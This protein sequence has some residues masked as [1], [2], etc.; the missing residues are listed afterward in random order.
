MK[1]V[2]DDI[3]AERDALLRRALA[4][5]FTAR[6][7]DQMK[8]DRDDLLRQSR[9]DVARIATLEEDLL[10]FRRA[11]LDFLKGQKECDTV[12]ECTDRSGSK[13]WEGAVLRTTEL[14]SGSVG[15]IRSILVNRFIRKLKKVILLDIMPSNPGVADFARKVHFLSSAQGACRQLSDDICERTREEADNDEGWNYAARNSLPT[16]SKFRPLN[17]SFVSE[18]RRKR[19]MPGG[20]L[21]LLRGKFFDVSTKE[22]RGA[23]ALGICWKND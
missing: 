12:H 3:K 21:L 9:D 20:E 13:E 19:R 16:L 10:I 5:A 6:A 15:R 11:A 22:A 23:A 8:T 4:D 7:F 18:I 2:Y 17:N 14:V 1:F